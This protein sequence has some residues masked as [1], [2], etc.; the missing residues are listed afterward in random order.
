M[1][2]PLAA[3]SQQNAFDPNYYPGFFGHPFL[4]QNGYHAVK[5]AFEIQLGQSFAYGDTYPAVTD[6][7]PYNSE[8]ATSLLGLT[9]AY[10]EIIKVM[11][12]PADVNAKPLPIGEKY[13][14]VV[15]PASNDVSVLDLSVINM[16]VI[17]FLG[18]D[19]KILK[20]V[21]TKGDATAGLL[22]LSLIN[23]ADGKNLQKMVAKLT[24]NDAS[25]IG[26]VVDEEG[27]SLVY[28]ISL[29]NAGV[30]ASLGH[31]MLVYYAFV[32]D[33]VEVPIIKKYYPYASGKAE[34]MV[35]GGSKLVDNDLENG[36]VTSVL[37]IG[38][39]YYTVKINEYYTRDCEDA[40]GVHKKGDPVTFPRG[41]EAGWV[42]TSGTALNLD[43]GDSYV[44]KGITKDGKEIKL[45][46][47]V[48]VLGLDLAGGGKTVLSFMTPDDVDLVGFKLDNVKVL[49]LELGAT[50]TNY[51]YIKAP[52]MDFL[53]NRILPFDAM[54][55]AVPG[56][57]TAYGGAVR[58]TY[59]N[60]LRFANNPDNP[61]KIP[62]AYASDA[63]RREV[64]QERNQGASFFGTLT[65]QKIHVVQLG[66]SKKV[67]YSDGTEG[68]PE[69]FGRFDIVMNGSSS[70]SVNSR[71]GA[72]KANT[73]YWRYLKNADSD[74]GNKYFAGT[75]T[76][77][78]DGVIDLSDLRLATY[79]TITGGWNVN[80]YEDTETQTVAENG[81]NVIGY[82]YGLYYIF[83]QDEAKDIENF[84]TE[85]M[86]L[87]YSYVNIPVNTPELEIAGTVDYIDTFEK[88]LHTN[89]G[90]VL[91]T[92][93]IYSGPTIES[94]KYH[95]YVS[96]AIADKFDDKMNVKSVTMY[97]YP[98]HEALQTYTLVDGNWVEQIDA[99][100]GKYWMGFTRIDEQPDGTAT[101]K[102]V[103]LVDD[104]KNGYKYALGYTFELDEAYKATLKDTY[105]VEYSSRNLNY[106]W[107]P[108]EEPEYN[109]PQL[110]NSEAT[111][112][113]ADDNLKVN[114]TWEVT[115]NSSK[116]I[117]D[118]QRKNNILDEEYL[119]NVDIL[120][121][122]WSTL[123]LSSS[124]RRIRAKAASDG[125]IE[126]PITDLNVNLNE[127]TD[128]EDIM[129]I[130]NNDAMTEYLGS[131]VAADNV[132]N[133]SVAYTQDVVSEEVYYSATTRAY[134]PIVPIGF[135]NIVASEDKVHDTDGLNNTI[136]TYLVIEQTTPEKIQLYG[137]FT[138]G[139][140][141]IANDDTGAPAEYY[142]TLGVKVQNPGTGVYV[143]RRGNVVTKELIRK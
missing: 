17:N 105:K 125:E 58:N 112:E 94:N 111:T 113:V 131:T 21:A 73:L 134:I 76:S 27:N 102:L 43:L 81:K 3:W 35:T 18:R 47:S 67:I 127:G 8:S 75:L 140:E 62:S 118:A 130:F 61:L 66:L 1:F 26:K 78:G 30:D 53:P 38:G 135:Q 80:P 84:A 68:E 57:T 96:W 86:A 44:M 128:A 91:S 138:T 51:A 52:T 137:D 45:A 71:L 55:E 41:V 99:N 95:H 4:E 103:A 33:Y 20:S 7:D 101:N 121:N 119:D 97:R 139:V 74:S 5:G 24:A 129:Y 22:G 69:N 60:D 14:F 72:Y 40:L 126:F 133:A 28:G 46:T 2:L 142:N 36:A 15:S 114:S 79:S 123:E 23:V 70:S 141:N 64:W 89:S 50:I 110:D 16:S 65:T 93:D 124:A 85:C 82:E 90:E 9:V 104:P 143:V 59:S 10:D 132:L 92:E 29:S 136:Q 6:T 106:E 120:Y 12:D 48:S 37:N 34:G 107:V 49:A 32:D 109:M 56:S 83:P 88:Q 117:H 19:G 54:I 63:E 116:R 25:D 13:G 115:L 98:N 122:L 11:P 108:G 39:A 31:E 77:D 100:K 42:I 87:D